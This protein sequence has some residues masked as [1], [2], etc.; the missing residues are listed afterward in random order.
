MATQRDIVAKVL[1]VLALAVV[2]VPMYEQ[3][4][5][6]R[7]IYGIASNEVHTELEPMAIELNTIIQPD[8]TLATH[9]IGA[10]AYFA[11]Y[12]VLD[13]VGL[14][15]ED[16]IRYHDK[17]QLRDYIELMRPDYVLIFGEWDRDYLHLDAPEHPEQYELVKEYPG[18]VV[19]WQT[20]LLYRMHYD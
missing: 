17:R 2:V 15:N 8:E 14:V 1:V 3:Y 19:R 10:V 9:D 6:W 16:A 18:G 20:Y 12:H 4:E 5:R 13:L 11:D 7:D